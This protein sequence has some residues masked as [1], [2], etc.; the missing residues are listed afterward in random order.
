MNYRPL[1]P[2]LKKLIEKSMESTRNKLY[3]KVPHPELD[4]LPVSHDNRRFEI[5][6]PHLA[7]PGGT[8]LDIGA[9]WGQ[10]SHWLEDKGYDV[11]AVEHAPKF[12]E[13]TKGLRDACMKKFELIEGSIFDVE[14]LKYDIVLALNIFHHFLR[15]EEKFEKFEAM[16]ARMDTKLIFFQSHSEAE[17][18]KISY[19]VPMEQDEFAE[20][21]L[22]RAGLD[23]YERIGTAHRR[24][25]YKIWRD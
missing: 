13:V 3:H 9:H 4:H 1:S 2:A 22:R 6:E 12:S 15:T 8:V 17:Q 21:V 20:F 14:N 18:R 10:F 25:L 5:I 16:L 11:T 23:N 7:Y 24:N 19:A